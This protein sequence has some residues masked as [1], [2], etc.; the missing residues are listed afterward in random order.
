MM[1]AATEKARLPSMNVVDV[2]EVRK[3]VEKAPPIFRSIIFYLG[4]TLRE[5]SLCGWNLALVSPFHLKC[6]AHGSDIPV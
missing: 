3:D 1:G 6:V 5:A 2:V 4:M